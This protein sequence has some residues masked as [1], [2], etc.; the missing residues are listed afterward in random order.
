MRLLIGA[1]LNVKA[2]WFVCPGNGPREGKKWRFE[3]SVVALMALGSSCDESGEV[4][5]A[6]LKTVSLWSAVL[7][8]SPQ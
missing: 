8:L 1:K 7:I 2:A 4:A 6:E 3:A 5:L